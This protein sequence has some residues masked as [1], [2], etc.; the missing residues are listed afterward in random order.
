MCAE[1]LQVE[2]VEAKH[3]GGSLSPQAK[4]KQY[5]SLSSWT[6]ASVVDNSSQTTTLQI[7]EKQENKVIHKQI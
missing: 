2:N 4:S 5:L 1:K 3:E 6:F 7:T